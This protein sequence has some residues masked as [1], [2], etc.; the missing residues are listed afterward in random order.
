VIPFAI[1]FL[2]SYGALAAFA[3]FT[4]ADGVETTV[5]NQLRPLGRWMAL[6][7]SPTPNL[8]PIIKSALNTEIVVEQGGAL[9]ESTL[10]LEQIQ[11][12]LSGATFNEED[13]AEIHL[14]VG[15]SFL[16]LRTRFDIP[17]EP[18]RPPLPSA[19]YLC[20]PSTI[21]AEQKA[22]AAG[23][24]A[25]LSAAGLLTLFVLGFF[26]ARSIAHPI[27]QISARAARI[28]DLPSPIEIPPSGG[29]IEQLARALNDMLSELK[30]SQARAVEA[31]KG[32]AIK[33][34]AASVAHEIK[35]PLQAVKLLIQMQ[36][37]LAPE[38]KRM[39]LGEIARIELASL[40]LLSVETPARPRQEPVALGSVVEETLDLLD[41]QLRHLKIRVSRDVAPVPE[42]PGD[43][44][45]L[46]R[47][48]MNLI[49]NGAQ[50]MPSG[51][52]LEVRLGRSDGAVRFSVTDA[53]AGVPEDVRPKLFE[54]FVTTKGDGVGLGLFVT[55]RI[56]EAHG[57]R[58]GFD[59]R[60][61]RTTFYFD[62]PCPT[63]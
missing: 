62:L 54:P 2:A 52:D 7:G 63:S 1:L 17:Q 3:V 53:G 21:L 36:S 16:V 12:P 40:E 13:L 60:P 25:A 34:L 37:G 58:L 55:R 5:V 24:L 15:G 14:Q 38:D 45:R 29:E 47:V 41:A 9:I 56:V 19:V 44:D 61:G 42:L 6:R 35:N 32:Q 22:K 59:S 11:R 31:E 28:K 50:A 10:P 26:I 18:G 8:L 51:G 43:P 49:L 48:V 39:L 33:T 23:P 20:Y 27:E 46:K 57:G 30:S 4:V